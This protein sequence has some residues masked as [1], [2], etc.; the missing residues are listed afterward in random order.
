MTVSV[1]SSGTAHAL[2]TRPSSLIDTI[3]SNYGYRRKLPYANLLTHLLSYPK[4][5]DAIASKKP[6]LESFAFI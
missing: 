5:R 3:A 6:F 1:M 4:S 2:V